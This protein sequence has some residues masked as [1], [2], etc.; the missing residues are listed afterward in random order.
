MTNRRQVVV[1]G[2]RFGQFYAAGIAQDSSY[3]LRGILSR[4]SARSRALSDSLGVEHWM[5][6][7]DVAD[8]VK[9][10]C[11]AVGGAVR[12]EMGVE[13]AEAFM[14]RGI[15][16]VIEHPLV[17]DELQ[18]LLRQAS[19]LKRRC[20]LNTFYL[21]LPVVAH[22][23]AL[24]RQLQ[25]SRGV[26]HM[27]ATCGVQLGVATLDVL[28]AGLQAVGPWSLQL[29]PDQEGCASSVSLVLG[30]TSVSLQVLNE[31]DAADDGR[32]AT[33]MRVEVTT[34][35]GVLCLL[36]P[37]GPLVWTPA[38]VAPASNANGLYVLGA[39]VSDEKQEALTPTFQL[40]YGES[41]P[42]SQVHSQL[43]PKACVAA[44]AVLDDELEIARCNQ[45]S[46]EV[47]LVW[48]RITDGIGFPESP[49]KSLR[50]ATLEDALE[51]QS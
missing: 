29:L 16:V 20:L 32:M 1:A 18:H 37:H 4:G 36:S 26:R 43:W 39:A 49:P 42:W 50:A 25:R 7:D 8:E 2:S 28:G 15:D 40:R 10:A 14:A 13:L 6:V 47:A 41:I 19:R 23:I 21:R 24:V 51:V 9:L 46:L 38:M 17:P 45:R 34:D 33:L 35:R 3:V 48:R 27:T 31:M 44:L 5:S 12:G 11:V 22:F 30:E